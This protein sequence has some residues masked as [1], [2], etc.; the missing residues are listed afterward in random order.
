[1]SAAR[2]VLRRRAVYL[3][4][5]AWTRVFFMNRR[6]IMTHTPLLSLAIV[7]ATSLALVAA[8]ALTLTAIQT[9]AGA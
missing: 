2:R 3:N 1:M 6:D 9:V 5:F 8:S 7:T 4:L